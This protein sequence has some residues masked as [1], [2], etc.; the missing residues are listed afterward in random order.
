MADVSAARANRGWK[1]VACVAVA[2]A[3]WDTGS[4]GWVGTDTEQ[5][6]LLALKPAC[7]VL[8]AEQQVVAVSIEQHVVAAASPAQHPPPASQFA[9]APQPVA[10]SMPAPQA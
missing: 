2:C 7:C 9:H 4:A 3:G 10:Q 1:C 8:P 6:Q 5:G